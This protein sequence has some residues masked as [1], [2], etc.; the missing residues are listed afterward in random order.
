LSNS[1]RFL[2]HFFRR[3][4]RVDYVAL[5]TVAPWRR[6]AVRRGQGSRKW[7]RRPRTEGLTFARRCSRGALSGWPGGQGEECVGRKEEFLG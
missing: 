7:E 5:V 4:A 2:L 3:T 1:L 6:V